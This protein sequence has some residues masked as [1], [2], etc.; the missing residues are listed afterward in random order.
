MDEEK[1]LPSKISSLSTL[2]NYGLKVKTILD[3]G[4]QYG[5]PELKKVFPGEKHVL[6][7]P[8]EEYWE[9][10]KHYYRNFDFELIEGAVSNQNGT[11][12]LTVQIQDGNIT[13]SRLA[14]Q[15]GGEK[16][17]VKTLTVASVVK[18][19]KYEGPFLLKIDIDGHDLEAFEGARDIW[20]DVACVVIEAPIDKI[21]PR[22][23]AIEEAGFVLWD[24][25]DLC[26][27]YKNLSQVDLVFVTPE[28]KKIHELS[29]W[30]HMPY[31]QEE[32]VDV[33]R[34]I[35]NW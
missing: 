32:W 33:A 8:I 24:I 3:V 5:T 14:F 10:M 22:L 28:L 18:E 1:R 16:R 35:E 2:K 19:K 15:G 21:G 26:Y 20:D 4:A 23:R 11:G 9:P 25:V 17:T 7:E 13:H 6:F 29:P 31:K 30:E 27:Y 34:V 12:E